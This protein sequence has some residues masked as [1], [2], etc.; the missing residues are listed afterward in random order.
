MQSFVSLALNDGNEVVRGAASVT[1][2]AE[3]TSGKVFIYKRM[4][5]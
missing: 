4:L 3:I 2:P 5:S 1:A